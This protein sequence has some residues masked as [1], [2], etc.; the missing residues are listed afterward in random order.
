MSAPGDRV[1]LVAITEE[2]QLRPAYDVLEKARAIPTSE[3]TPLLWE[4][5][6]ALVPVPPLERAL[7]LRDG[8]SVFRYRTADVEHEIAR[9]AAEQVLA[10][11]L[12]PFDGWVAELI[13]PVTNQPR[14]PSETDLLLPL[15]ELAGALVKADALTRTIGEQLALDRLKR[16]GVQPLG[17]ARALLD[18]AIEAAA[19][20]TASQAAT[21]DPAELERRLAELRVVAA[22]LL[23]TPDPLA[24]VCEAIGPLFGGDRKVPLLVYLAVTTRLL[25]QRPGSMPC[26]T[27]IVG[28]S[29]T[30]K[31]YALKVVLRLFPSAAYVEIDAGT[32]RILIYDSRPVQHR[33]VIFAEQD[34]IPH[35]E[36]NPAAS[37]LRHLL[38]ENE[39]RWQVVERDAETGEFFVHTVRRRGP[40]V[41]FTTGT[42][43]FPEQMDTRVFSLELAG[44]A[45]Q[46]RAALK[47]QGDL[48]KHGLP[49]PNPAL[50]A[51]QEFLQLQA[52]WDVVVPYSATL[53][54]VIGRT[55][56]AP[57]I[58]RDY[59][60]LLALVKALAV[61]RHV[62]RQRDEQGR[63]VATLEDYGTVYEL[64]R[65][66][67]EGEA[68]G[69]TEYVRRAVEVVRVVANA[70]PGGATVREVAKALNV[71]E[72]SA[73]RYVQR[74]LRQRWLTNL[75]E[76]RYRPARLDMGDPMPERAGLPEPSHLATV[77]AEA[78]IP[79]NWKENSEA[80]QTTGETPPVSQFSQVSALSKGEV[81]PARGHVPRTPAPP[82]RPSGR[83]AP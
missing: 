60:K 64:V 22:P 48:E 29:S 35:D 56:V 61:L 11:V 68:S 10:P 25:Q 50:V 58:L 44:D 6:A 12:A 80:T 8:Q 76:R 66:M 7:P 31:S 51:F 1:R 72:T 54:E 47:T 69:A 42:K 28:S 53:A 79:E 77:F 82:A 4:F 36:D 18:A 63:L 9:I 45:D 17:R 65:D 81:P 52:P 32:P 83:P 13:N 70:R 20:A 21:P 33:A 27:L 43:R 62:H 57:R 34:S 2:N 75:E 46:V 15:R 39:L 30:G 40:S 5:V 49:E 73:W 71:G 78:P 55:L 14:P 37:A 24:L 67:Y 3:R 23:G 26:H 19:E 41:L 16:L 38:Q 59:L 74:A